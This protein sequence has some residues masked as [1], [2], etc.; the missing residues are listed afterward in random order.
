VD[1]VTDS[2]GEPVQLLCGWDVLKKFIFKLNFSLP[3]K[4][5]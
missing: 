3:V 5:R 4:V 1:R 2:T